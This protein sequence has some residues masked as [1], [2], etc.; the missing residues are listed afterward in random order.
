MT[1]FK[2]L[3][4]QQEDKKLKHTVIGFITTQNKTKIL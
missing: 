4:S 1:Y 2:V 3:L